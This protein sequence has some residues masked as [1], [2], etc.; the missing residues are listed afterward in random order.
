MGIYIHRFF[1]YLLDYGEIFSLFQQYNGDRKFDAYPVERENWKLFNVN[2]VNVSDCPKGTAFDHLMT[3]RMNQSVC[4]I[5]VGD[6]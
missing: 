2:F 5:S 3:K 1:S 6:Q 4:E